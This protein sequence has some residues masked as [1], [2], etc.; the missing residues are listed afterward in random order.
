MNKSSDRDHITINKKVLLGVAPAVAIIAILLSK[1]EPG[2]L[3]LFLV[4][5]ACGILIG[6]HLKSTKEKG[7]TAS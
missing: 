4:G 7:P 2:P 1:R 3:I 5:I 6:I